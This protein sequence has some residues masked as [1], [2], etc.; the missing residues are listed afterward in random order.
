VELVRGHKV[1]CD[2]TQTQQTQ[3]KLQNNVLNRSL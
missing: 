1:M 2:L 3:C